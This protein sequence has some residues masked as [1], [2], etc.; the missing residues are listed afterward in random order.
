[1][2]A[3]ITKLIDMVKLICHRSVR[4]RQRGEK[5]DPGQNGQNGID[6]KDG[7]NGIT[8][9]SHLT[10]WARNNSDTNAPTSWGTNPLSPTAS[11]RYVW[12]KDV[13]TYDAPEK[14]RN[15]LRNTKAPF[16]GTGGWSADGASTITNVTNDLPISGIDS[17][18]QMVSGSTSYCNIQQYMTLKAG[19]LT[20]SCYVKG[21]SGIS[22]YLQPFW[23]SGSTNPSKSFACN[24]SWQKISFTVD[25]PST[26]NYACGIIGMSGQGSG[27]TIKIGAMKMEYGEDATD[28][29]Q[30]PEDLNR[31]EVC[32]WS[33]FGEKG[34][35]GHAGRFFYYAGQYNHNASYVIGETQAPYVSMVVNG[36]KKFF[37]LDLQ[38]SEPSSLPFTATES[39]TANGQLQ[40]TEMQSQHKYYIMEA[41][42]A[43]SA[44][45]GSLVIYGNWMI[46]QHGKLNGSDSQSYEYFYENDPRGESSYHFAPH[47]C[48]NMLTG[49]VYMNNSFLRGEFEGLGGFLKMYGKSEPIYSR[50]GTIVAT[51]IN[52]YLKMY[53]PDG[54]EVLSI[55]TSGLDG[56]DGTA[57]IKMVNT[58]NGESVEI[59]PDLIRLVDS[60]QNYASLGIGNL[61]IY[62]S[63]GD[64]IEIEP[65]NITLTKNGD[66]YSGVTRNIT[67]GGN[68]L[69]FIAGI[70]VDV[71]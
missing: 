36:V 57:K 43:E 53:A 26:E 63:D 42:F 52:N 14:G 45:L 5:G 62:D 51:V 41:V 46:S 68:T 11:N 37:M 56:S 1:M 16:V 6:G 59:T 40:W 13:W 35:D 30:A 64:Y 44:Y 33:I 69:H 58:G 54:D 66:L 28:W 2:C 65:Y 61:T 47:F 60:N 22:V 55:E 4:F 29:C 3:I 19:K 21:N 15:L 50:L 20:L 67:V 12:R 70:L 39:P 23:K 9:V 48:V 8:L 34:Q 38:G 10:Y 31:E 18:L 49:T 7:L 25:V 27:K 71:T 24:G 32:V 17:V